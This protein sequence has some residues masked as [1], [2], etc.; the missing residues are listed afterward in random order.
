MGPAVVGRRGSRWARAG[1]PQSPQPGATHS[2]ASQAPPEPAQARRLLAGGAWR[3]QRRLCAPTLVTPAQV[4]RCTGCTARG[5]PAVGALGPG[6][7]PCERLPR[8]PRGPGKGLRGPGSRRA[9][10]PSLKRGGEGLLGPRPNSL[11]RASPLHPPRL[12]QW[13]KRPWRRLQFAQ[14]PLK[15][16]P[17]LPSHAGGT[18]RAQPEMPARGSPG[19]AALQLSPC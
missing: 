17:V 10:M 15:L 11:E 3:R 14:T 4:H 13:R 5:P 19:A 12:R 8:R 18:S 9:P 2:C 6:A 16:A 7:A 1:G